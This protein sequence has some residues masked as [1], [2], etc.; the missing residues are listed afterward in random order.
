MTKYRIYREKRKDCRYEF[1]Y[2]YKKTL[3]GWKEMDYFSELAT[4]K[5][6]IKEWEAISREEKPVFIEEIEVNNVWWC[7]NKL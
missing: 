1:Y 4:C 6:K 3:F 5:E 2:I 7:L